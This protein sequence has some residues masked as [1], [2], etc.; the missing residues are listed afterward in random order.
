M[1]HS[2]LASRLRERNIH[3]IGG[4]FFNGVRMLTHRDVNREDMQ[5]VAEN[6]REIM[7]EFQ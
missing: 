4:G 6:V 7:S 1:Q 2:D 3:C 5:V